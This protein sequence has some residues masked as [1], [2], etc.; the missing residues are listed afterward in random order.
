MCKEQTSW[1]LG[2]LHEAVRDQD[3]SVRRLALHSAARMLP[4]LRLEWR[5]DLVRDLT[6]QL[7]RRLQ[8]APA[9]G[10]AALTPS[11]GARAEEEEE[12][13][14]E[15]A[16]AAAEALA[17]M[18]PGLELETDKAVDGL[19][20]DLVSGIAT[21]LSRSAARDGGSMAAGDG[22]R[23]VELAA[24]HALTAAASAA[25]GQLP[26]ALLLEARDAIDPFLLAQ[27]GAAAASPTVRAI[28]YTPVRGCTC[29]APR[30][31]VGGRW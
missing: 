6:R 4:A 22:G 10:E 23:R 9:P 17:A 13:G 1:A 25:R 31:W 18:M 3:K 12:E 2:T 8:R 26:P 5:S 7:V 15:E 27:L 11:A 19:L 21:L 16:A 30:C 28:G 20:P 29:T 14:E 24:L